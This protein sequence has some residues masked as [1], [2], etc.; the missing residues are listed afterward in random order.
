MKGFNGGATKRVSIA[1]DRPARLAERA[2][3]VTAGGRYGE[4]IA[5]HLE[6]NRIPGAADLKPPE[7]GIR[8]QILMSGTWVCK[9]LS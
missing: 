7:P 5:R 1:G 4:A 8:E 6:D 2:L 9:V 3:T